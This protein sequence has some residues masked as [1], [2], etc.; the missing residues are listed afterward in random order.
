MNLQE[1]FSVPSLSLNSKSVYTLKD[2][3]R[4]EEVKRY[5]EVFLKDWEEL[6][7]LESGGV[8]EDE[9]NKKKQEILEEI[10]EL[11]RIAEK[12]GESEEFSNILNSRGL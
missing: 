3:A 5:V 9:I 4:S 12:N 7:D 6:K 1:T 8:P 10:Q 11:R 2:L